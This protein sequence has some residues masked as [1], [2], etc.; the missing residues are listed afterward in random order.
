MKAGDKCRCGDWIGTYHGMTRTGNYII[1]DEIS[2]VGS[3]DHAIPYV[4]ENTALTE[5]KKLAA[6]LNEMIKELEKR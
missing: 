4:E 2:Y 6:E 1:E 5:V 3:Y